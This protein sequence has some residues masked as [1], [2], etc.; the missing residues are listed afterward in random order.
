MQE[1]IEKEVLKEV[2]HL[3]GLM[4]HT[5]TKEH[6]GF[7]GLYKK[8]Y[9]FGK[10]KDGQVFLHDRLGNTIRVTMQTLERTCKEWIKNEKLLAA[11]LEAAKAKAA[12]EGTS[13]V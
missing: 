3:I 9:M 5:S 12:K 8:D 7:L 4:S 2:L 6:D 1:N 11:D 10:V 13:E